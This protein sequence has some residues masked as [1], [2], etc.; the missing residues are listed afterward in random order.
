MLTMQDSKI[1]SGI[2]QVIFAT[3]PGRLPSPLSHLYC[4]ILSGKQGAA[5]SKSRCSAQAYSPRAHLDDVGLPEW[6]SMC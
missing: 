4:C 2:Q 1:V 3:K 5:R 6:T